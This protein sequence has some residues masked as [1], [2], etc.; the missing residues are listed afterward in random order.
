M[1]RLLDR[2]KARGHADA[3]DRSGQRCGVADAGAAQNQVQ[4]ATLGCGI[5]GDWFVGTAI[6]VEENDLFGR[7]RPVKRAHAHRAGIRQP[8]AATSR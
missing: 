3:A 5:Q 6:R 7:H 4:L 8:A 1:G 2:V